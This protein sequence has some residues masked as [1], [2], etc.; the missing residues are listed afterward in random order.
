MPRRRLSVPPRPAPT[1][2]PCPS[3]SPLAPRV[4]RPAWRAR[5]VFR[6]GS[7]SSVGPMAGSVPFLRVSGAG[8]VKLA[9]HPFGGE[10]PPV[11]LVHATGFHGRCWT[12][13]AA[14]LSRSFTVWALDL[15]G[16]GASGKA[17]DGR[18]DDWDAFAGDLL[19]AVD[20]VGGADW[21]A[22]GHSLGGA[23]CLLAEARRP[24][25]FS[26]IC[27]YEP[28]VFPPPEPGGS[29]E[30]TGA[31]S[32]AQLARKRRPSFPSRQ[33]ALDNYRSKPPFT[34]FD[35]VALDCYVE[36]GL[37]DQ[38]D[39]GVT[40][41]CIREDEAAVFEG[42]ARNPTWGQLPSVR[43]PV[44]VLG[45]ADP[46]DAVGR[47]APDVARRLPRGGYRRF[48]HLD[49]FGP[50]TAPAEVG[51]VMRSAL[52]IGPSPGPSTIAVTSPH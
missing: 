51:E 31:N 39:G 43:A 9:V 52:S 50:L 7:W 21:R 18:Y 28:V 6:Q 35:P 17:P 41:A 25:V 22:A 12:P 15:R 16:H 5:T 44:A 32:L 49:H 34:S 46:E 45:G 2:G 19:A 40:L 4:L 42:V 24:G 10:G 37:V 27:C 48:D 3:P 47:I 1:P 8:G 20:A 26:A 38:P 29:G 11:M 14:V 13:L 30:G 23:V 33:A 36:F